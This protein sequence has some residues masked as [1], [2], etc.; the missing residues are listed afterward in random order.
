MAG[1]TKRYKRSWKNLLI[2]K[3]YQLRFTLFMVG[4]SV[5]L[6]VG[7]GFWVMRVATTSHTVAA[8]DLYGAMQTACKD[9]SAAPAAAP[10]A[11]APPVGSPPPVEAA[12]A[13]E[14]A[15][16]E[17]TKPVV[18][19][20]ATMMEDAPPAATVA[21]VAPVVPDAAAIAR[22]EACKKKYAGDL[23]ELGKRKDHIV[24]ALFAT[25][26]LLTLGL[27]IYGIKMTHKVA[28]PLYKISLYL[29]KLKNGTYDTVYNLRKGDELSEF[30]EHFKLAHAGVKKMQQEDV[31]RL[32]AAIAAADQAGLAAKSPEVAAALDELR[33]LLA[34]KEKTVG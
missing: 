23:A 19:I 27:T 24:Y 18:T 8:N 7:L 26:L 29:D 16:R 21:P 22:F 28:G 4:M 3:R 33:A 12:P 15:E 30:Y 31:A 9:P 25:G 32:K 13:A 34:E 14:P 10:A 17:R 2:N 5:L 11:I 6:M 1:Q 20:D